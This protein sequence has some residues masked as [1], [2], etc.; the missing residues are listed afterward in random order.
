MKFPN[1]IQVLSMLEILHGLK[2]SGKTN[3]EVDIGLPKSSEYLSSPY[4]SSISL[5]QIQKKKQQQKY[6]PT[7]LCPAL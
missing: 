7:Y 6:Q 4:Y 5:L 1:L 2:H 3:V